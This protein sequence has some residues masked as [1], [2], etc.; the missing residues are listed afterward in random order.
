ML[1]FYNVAKQPQMNVSI[2]STSR[3][4][5]QKRLKDQRIKK[6]KNYIDLSG[7]KYSQNKPIRNTRNVVVYD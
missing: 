1:Y 2:C 4:W 3:F 5:S 7:K 6:I